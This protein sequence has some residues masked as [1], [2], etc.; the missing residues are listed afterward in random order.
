MPTAKKFANVF[1]IVA[2]VE[3][4]V[5]LLAAGRLRAFDRNAVEG[6]WQEFDVVRVRAAYLN[7]QGNATSVSEQRPLDSQFATIGRV[8]PGFFPHPEATLSS[9]RP[10]SASSTRCLL[11]RRTP[12]TLP[13]TACG[14]RPRR[15]IVESND[16]TCC[17]KQTR[18][19]LLSIG[20]PCA[21]RK[22]FH[23]PLFSNQ[24]VAGRPGRSFDGGATTVASVSKVHRV[25]TKR[26]ASVISPS[27]TPP[28][29]NKMSDMSLSVR[30]AVVSCSVSG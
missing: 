1:G 28:C 25:D 7:A 30:R 9:L 15:P 21:T 27:A 6:G 24:I 29:K 4:D 16:V 8:F 17:P 2:F 12:A 10:H 3:T 14:I 11:A 23:G 18:V 20:S 5:L 22:R 19:A 26:S 13:S